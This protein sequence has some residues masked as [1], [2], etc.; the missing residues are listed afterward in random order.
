MN[1]TYKLIYNRKDKL[2]AEGKALLQLRVYLNRTQ[3][4]FSTGFYLKPHEWNGEKIIKNPAALRMN[5][6]LRDLVSGLADYELQV[7]QEG[8]V[9][10]FGHVKQFMKGSTEMEFIKFCRNQLEENKRIKYS[11]YRA[12]NAKLNV[13]EKSE[14]LIHFSDLTYENIQRLDNWLRIDKKSPRTIF[15]YH[16]VLKTFINDAIKL[17]LIAMQNNPY[18]HFKPQR[19]PDAKRRYL[20]KKEI[21]RIEEKEFGNK[22]LEQIKDVFLFSIYTGLS[23][24]D[25]CDLKKDDLYVDDENECWIWRD[26]VKVQEAQYR[27]PLL[28]QA[29]TILEKYRGKLPVKSNQRMNAY[30]KEIADICDIRKNLTFHMARHTFATT[31]TLSNSVPISTVSKMMGHKNLRTTQIYAKIVDRKMMDDMKMLREK[32]K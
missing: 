5:K 32:M 2:N 14:I 21:K 25:I 7:K 4:Y 12:I 8:K 28:P 24:S 15:K 6:Q 19:V 23:Y 22:R 30:L 29:A 1:A 31:I 3:K 17:D 27:V 16:S 18:I 10:G 13:L 20:D 26:R 9:F 11:T